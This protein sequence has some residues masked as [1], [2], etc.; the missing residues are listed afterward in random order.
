MPKVQYS[1]GIK[2][3]SKDD[4]K[5]IKFLWGMM[6]LLEKILFSQCLDE[7]NLDI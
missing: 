4:Q 3:K 6:S 5:M 1:L 7:T 2:E